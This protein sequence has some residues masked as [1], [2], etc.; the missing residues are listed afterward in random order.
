MNALMDEVVESY[1]NTR[2]EDDRLP[3]LTREELRSMLRYITGSYNG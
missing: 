2:R 1:C 3:S